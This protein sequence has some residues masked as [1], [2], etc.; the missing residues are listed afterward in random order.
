[1]ELLK[2]YSVQNKEA[3]N[4]RKET[5]N[6]MTLFTSACEESFPLEMTSILVFWN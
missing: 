6:N 4:K 3:K 1:M 2:K 5:K